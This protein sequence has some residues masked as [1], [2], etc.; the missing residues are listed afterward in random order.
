MTDRKPDGG[1]AF[2]ITESMDDNSARV[3]SYGMSMRDYFAA[4]A[5]NAGLIHY[6]LSAG[7]EGAEARNAYAMADAMLAERS[8]S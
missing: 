6:G 2:P 5:L 1:C 8:K 7:N 4:A 3:S